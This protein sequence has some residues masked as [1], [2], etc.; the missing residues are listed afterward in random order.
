M[1]RIDSSYPPPNP[2]PGGTLSH[3]NGPRADAGNGT[4]YWPGELTLIRQSEDA[5]DASPPPF[6]I[7][8]EYQFAYHYN[9]LRGHRY[10][11]PSSDPQI[12]SSQ[13]IPEQ[14]NFRSQYGS[15]VSFPA[16]TGQPFSS[17]PAYN[18]TYPE[19]RS[20]RAP[21][22]GWSSQ[23]V[24]VSTPVTPDDNFGYSRFDGY[25]TTSIGQEAGSIA[26]PFNGKLH[27]SCGFPCRSRCPTVY[28]PERLGNADGP[29]HVLMD[30]QSRQSG[31][32]LHSPYQLNIIF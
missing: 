16:N 17:A 15:E 7:S 21:R 22:T 19:Y 29:H 10:A 14:S 5:T 3:P 31:V 12:T 4:I 8:G 13:Q 20:S 1:A 11:H 23:E 6:Y 25:S 28:S 18:T 30:P 9:T 27:I 2:L 24:G 26:P 32:N